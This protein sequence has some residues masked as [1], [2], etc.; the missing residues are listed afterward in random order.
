MRRPLLSLAAW[1][2]ALVLIQQAGLPH[3]G[4]PPP[5]PPG[6]GNIGPGYPG[7]G[8]PGGPGTGGP[9]DIVPPNPPPGGPNTPPPVAKPPVSGGGNLPPGGAIG[10]PTRGP[11]T[12]GGAKKQ[13]ASSSWD[14]WEVWWE[15][16]KDPY[17][18][19]RVLDRSS[20]TG[21]SG[22][23][24]GAGNRENAPTFTGPSRAMVLERIV[25]VLLQA[26]TESDAEILDSAALALGRVVPGEAGEEVVKSL[27]ETLKS[28]HPTARQSAILALGICGHRASIP[29]LWDLMND[30]R[31]GRALVRSGGAVGGIDRAF[32]AM[33]LG[34]VGGAEMVPQLS[35]VIERTE[36]R[37]IEV[38]AGAVLSLGL[39]NLEAQQVIPM[40][41]ARL[42]DS[43]VDRRIRAQ[44]PVTL[45]RLGEAAS[46]VVPTLLK[47]ASGRGVDTDVRRSC[48]I[49]LGRIARGSDQAVVSELRRL[50]RKESDGLIR[51]FALIALGKMGATSIG[52]SQRDKAGA[53]AIRSY[54]K[55]ELADPGRSVDLPWIALATGILGRAYGSGSSD[56]TE[57]GDQMLALLRVTG[58]P[59]KQG[60]L[61]IALGLMEHSDA[62]PELLSLYGESHDSALKGYLAVGLGLVDHGEAR[63]ALR[64]DLRNQN[65]AR[66]RVEV[67]T[68]LGLLGDPEAA[69]GLIQMLTDAPTFAVTASVAQAL[70]RIGDHRAVEP[71]LALIVDP[72]QN[73]AVRGFSCVAVGLIAEKTELPWNAPLSQ[74]SNYASQVRA[75]AEVLDIF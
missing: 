59:S 13:R 73:T 5:D 41:L 12:G 47:L 28:R 75:Q 37:D 62:G 42:A 71:L 34:F 22:L 40:L 30:T 53:D 21:R 17:L 7:G 16:N 45:G 64:D 18:S 70:G 3:G 55:T 14:G 65:D 60:A 44:I 36:G 4:S 68:G 51:H 25:P 67:A 8:G 56:R 69:N 48:V 24:T 27:R 46:P 66:L 52:E 23:L 33:A 74:D 26:L 15:F 54:L 63:A 57:L 49:A 35:R 61:A 1:F 39:I 29:L 9:G 43:K 32:A 19:K 2:C 10:G 72:A 11:S 38:V 50:I 20:L 31:K 6:P 58:D